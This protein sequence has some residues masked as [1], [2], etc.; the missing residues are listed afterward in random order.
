[1]TRIYDRLKEERHALDF[2]DLE[3]QT[4]ALLAQEPQSERLRAYLD[5]INH[6]MVDEFQDTNHIQKEIVSFLAP[7]TVPGRLFVVGDAKQS[8][9]RFRQA[10]VSIFNQTAH[11]VEQASGF[12]PQPLNRSFRTHQE[13]VDGVNHLFDQILQPLDGLKHQ[14]FE[15]QPGALTAARSD[16]FGC[17]TAH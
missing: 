7:A 3:R 6:L 17:R 1:M 13:L 11:E 5:S 12:P 14:P 16:P 8:I 9:Y 10:Q 4:V 15:A 2:D